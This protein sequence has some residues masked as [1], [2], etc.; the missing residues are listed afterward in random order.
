MAFSFKFL[1]SSVRNAA[2]VGSVW[3]LLCAPAFADLRAVSWYDEGAAVA[4]WHY[5]VP[6]S[7]P[8]S[9]P[10]GATVELD[11]DFLNL[12]TNMNID[13]SAVTFDVNS[14]RIVRSEG[15]LAAEQEFIDGIFNGALDANSN[16]RGQI[17]F[18][19]EDAA[20]SGEYY[21]Y[22]DV[23]VNGAKPVNP[24]IVIN[25]HFELSAGTTPTRWTTSAQNVLGDQNNEVHTTNLG[26][27]I[28]LAGGCGTGGANNLDVS[29]NSIAGNATGRNWH[30][31]GFRDLCED[32][33]GGNERVQLSRSFAVPASSAGVLE[34]Y[35]QVQ[36]FD[37][38][39][40]GSNYDWFEF[41]VNGATV[42]HRALGIDNSTSPALDIDTNRLGRAGYG[43]LRDHGWKRARLN[44]AAFSGTTITFEVE[45][46]HSA[47]DDNYRSWIKLDDFIW[48]RQVG[49]LG[50][51]EAYGANVILP[52][53]TSVLSSGEYVIND[54]LDIRV[55][56]DVDVASVLVDVIDDNGVL[57]T[58]GITLFDD[59]SHGD[60]LAGDRVWR[61]DGSIGAEPT[62][63][64]TAGPFGTNWVVR[65]FALDQSS[66]LGST[67]SGLMMIP[68]GDPASETQANFYN[69]DEQMFTLRGALVDIAKSL[70]TLQDF[71]SVSEPKSI[72]GAWVR[73]EVR[74]E[75]QGPD[76]LN[77]D[78]ITVV[79]EIPTEVALC[80]A[81][82]CTCVGP[83]C[84]TFDPVQ[85]DDSTSPITTGLSLDYATQ[86]E[87]STDGVSY[88][89]TPIPDAD[90]FDSNVRFVRVTPS[91][92]MSQPSGVNNA[93][94]E[95]TYVVRLE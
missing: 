52:N 71:A 94:F 40:N 10:I 61:N 8:V 1:T 93:E 31:V 15:S 44:L 70:E 16:A 36:A 58:A 32:G 17:R 2:I 55:I 26:Q 86:V 3:I 87:Y 66:A 76:G 75:N 89:Y 60:T 51:A 88:T 92:A 34:F 5:R 45:S 42:N 68:G 82:T 69:I 91:G 35:F 25:G 27:T 77:L 37:G 28:N 12:L 6:I 57:V 74:V 14:P 56:V 90:G 85:F 49:T 33:A 81:A 9:S 7:M 64:F 83:S 24:A 39:S 30:L 73:Y 78:S 62:F 4:D 54:V 41:S 53:D 95:L 13:T 63:T 11:V 20:A 46:R 22:F 72:P 21:L 67:T 47:S 50:L 19:Q 18:I 23:M 29:P 48:S 84:T 38:I 65:A 43:G 80:V 79:D 59:G